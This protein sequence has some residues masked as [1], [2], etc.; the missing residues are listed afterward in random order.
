MS[1]ITDASI[2]RD[3]I[4][5]NGLR[6]SNFKTRDASKLYSVQA[7]LNEV[8]DLKVNIVNIESIEELQPCLDRLNREFQKRSYPEYDLAKEGIQ[9][10]LIDETVDANIPNVKSKD[11]IDIDYKMAT[12]VLKSYLDN[13]TTRLEIFKYVCVHIAD[14][15][16]GTHTGIFPDLGAVTWNLSKNLDELRAD[17]FRKKIIAIHLESNILEIQKSEDIIH[18]AS[19]IDSLIIFSTFVKQPHLKTERLSDYAPT[20]ASLKF[21]DDDKIQKYVMPDK[22]VHYDFKRQIT[23][24]KPQ[25]QTQRKAL[26]KI[27]NSDEL[28]VKYSRPILNENDSVTSFYRQ[29]YNSD[30]IYWEDYK[31]GFLTESIKNRYIEFYKT[32]VI[33]SNSEFDIESRFLRHAN[34]FLNFKEK[35]NGND[36][37]ESYAYYFL[38]SLDLFITKWA[39]VNQPDYEATLSLELYHLLRQISSNGVKSNVSVNNSQGTTKLCDLM[40][41]NKETALIIKAKYSRNKELLMQGLSQLENEYKTVLKEYEKQAYLVI[42]MLH[43]EK[44]KFMV[45]MIL[46]VAYSNDG[47]N[48]ST[49]PRISFLTLYN[50]IGEKTCIHFD[51]KYKLLE[52][53]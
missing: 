8:L 27:I 41:R 19:E 38:K 33:D 17:R 26:Y 4:E 31:I 21:K 25:N 50:T 44:N 3:V 10:L 28:M 6:F 46:Q 5:R 29:L 51:Q 34:D 30:L 36:T 22:K 2:L 20:L 24:V 12:V 23:L 18:A 53:T 1:E 47:A 45:S 13:I 39:E 11:G 16:I 14:R 40:F 52:L 15:D 35:E 9:E 48:K 7:F 37:M 42:D 43:Q 32:M 49:K